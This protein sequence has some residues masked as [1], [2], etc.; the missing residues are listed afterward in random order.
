MLVVG[1]VGL[2]GAVVGKSLGF[3]LRNI[4][5][6]VLAAPLTS[7]VFIAKKLNFSVWI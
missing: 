3:K 5:V 6:P 4:W 2:Y 7:C 1:G